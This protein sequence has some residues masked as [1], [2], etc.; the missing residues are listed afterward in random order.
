MNPSIFS[1]NLLTSPL[2]TPQTK[3][4][5]NFPQSSSASQLPI[6]IKTPHSKNNTNRIVFPQLSKVSTRKMLASN[7]HLP[8]KTSPSPTFSST[9]QSDKEE[10][11]LDAISKRMI[12]IHH[13]VK[14]KQS[15]NSLFSLQNLM[16]IVAGPSLTSLLGH[17]SLFSMR[18]FVMALKKAVMEKQR[19]KLKRY[20]DKYSI[21][22]DDSKDKGGVIEMSVYIRFMGRNI[23]ITSSFLSFCELD[24]RGASAPVL[25]EFLE[26][27]LLE[28]GLNPR[29]MIALAS[30]GATNMS[31][32]LNGVFA[33]FRRKYKIKRLIFVHCAAHRCNLLAEALL[34]YSSV[35]ASFSE[36]LLII[37]NIASI[38]NFSY[39]K[40]RKLNNIVKDFGF[41]V[42]A[43]P[44]EGDTRW[45]ARFGG[46]FF[47]P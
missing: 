2:K 24:E 7:S 20:K 5:V 17:T 23:E 47:F 43:I 34:Y 11:F 30:D 18:E 19:L 37:S 12:T 31:G 13:I 6:P 40:R 25:L 32:Y 35:S 38:F 14:N 26:G 28:W 4:N 33:L 15:N 3:Q 22:I 8:H 9:S 39:L 21:M 10:I 42:I 36:T 1:P 29:Y 44:R 27:V 45:M 46:F 16:D 41:N